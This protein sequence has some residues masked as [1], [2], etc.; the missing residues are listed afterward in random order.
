[1]AAKVLQFPTNP[2]RGLDVPLADSSPSGAL[3]VGQLRE[4]VNGVVRAAIGSAGIGEERL[5]TAE[6]ASAMLSVSVDWLY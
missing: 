4:L 1:M 5:L 6:D 3:T 2:E